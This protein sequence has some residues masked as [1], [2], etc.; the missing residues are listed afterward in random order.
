MIYFFICKI[1]VVNFCFA[2][3]FKT[4]LPLYLCDIPGCLGVYSGEK[5]NLKLTETH[6]PL[7]LPPGMLKLKTCTP[8][9]GTGFLILNVCIFL[10]MGVLSVCM[11]VHHMCA[12]G[13]LLKVLDLR[14]AL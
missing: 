10:H 12:Q 13:G 3:C 9:L 11:S 1:Q 14:L 6:L 2:C 7:P 5:A 4:G 8:C